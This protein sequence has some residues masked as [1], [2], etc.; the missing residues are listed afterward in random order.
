MDTGSCSTGPRVCS[1]QWAIEGSHKV[2]YYRPMK[3]ERIIYF[4]LTCLG[5]F[6][7]L[8]L[9]TKQQQE[10]KMQEANEPDTSVQIRRE[11]G[12]RTK[13]LLQAGPRALSQ[14]P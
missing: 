6:F 7:L 2:L 11:Q 10:R 3:N 9:F 5:F 4:I 14:H 12:D 13:P 8:C 1:P